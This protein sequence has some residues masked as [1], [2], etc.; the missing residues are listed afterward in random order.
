MK[1]IALTIALLAVLIAPMSA[2]ACG[3]D[4][5]QYRTGTGVVTMEEAKQI[6]ANYL[7]T[8]DTRLS[9]GDIQLEG[10]NYYVTVNDEN[11]KQVA[12]LS[13]DMLTG[14]IRPVF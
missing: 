8:I 9:A 1:K 10:Q 11:N 2:L 12:R 7:T 13:I 6:T 14:S 3:C 5:N 4:G